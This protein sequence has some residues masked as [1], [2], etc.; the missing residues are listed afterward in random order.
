[1]I[2]RPIFSPSWRA[3]AERRRQERITEK[4]MALVPR[5]VV[6]PRW[7]REY[8]RNSRWWVLEASRGYPSSPDSVRYARNM[9]WASELAAL[10]G[11]GAWL[12][13]IERAGVRNPEAGGS[14]G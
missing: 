13:L 5:R 2:R 11:P 7:P 10:H 6:T 1:V 9:R 14:R 8:R 4:Q 3:R 12:E